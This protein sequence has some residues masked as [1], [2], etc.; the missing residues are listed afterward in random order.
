MMQMHPLKGKHNMKKILFLMLFIASV[1]Q[2]ASLDVGV[3]AYDNGDYKTAYEEFSVL[4]E[5]GSV[6]AQ[7][8]LAVMYWN[9]EGATQDD[10]QAYMWLI[11]AK[12]NGISD[13]ERSIQLISEKMTTTSINQAQAMAKKCLQSNYQDCY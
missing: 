2:A 7:S 12:Y 13:V 11:L 4:A 10:K 1:A 8:N 6:L 9:G 5:Q 3:K